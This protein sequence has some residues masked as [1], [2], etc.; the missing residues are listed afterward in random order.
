MRYELKSVGLWAFLKVSFFFN[1]ALGFIFGLLYS[2]VAGFVIAVM[3]RMPEFYSEFDFPVEPAPV[4][5]MLVVM[6]IVFAVLGAVF[7]TLVEVVM[8]LLYNVIARIVGGFEFNLEPMAEAPPS[9]SGGPPLTAQTGPPS[10]T[11]PPPGPATPRSLPPEPN[12]GGDEP[13]SGRGQEPY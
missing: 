12:R 10:Y 3:S 6:P 13:G 11:P 4:G 7:Y 8:V 1:L 5:F 2:L 9:P